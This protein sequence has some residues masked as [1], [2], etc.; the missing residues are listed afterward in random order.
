MSISQDTDRLEITHESLS[1]YLMSRYPNRRFD[2]FP[3]FLTELVVELRGGGFNTIDDVHNILERTKTATEHFEDENPRSQ[4]VGNRYSAIE[5][6]IISIS[7]LYN[8]F[9]ISWPNA[10][11]NFPPE[12]LEGYRKLILPETGESHLIEA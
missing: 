5:I 2:D 4:L 8:D 1:E 7:L 3:Y 12:K 11:D 6:V 9:F 10:L